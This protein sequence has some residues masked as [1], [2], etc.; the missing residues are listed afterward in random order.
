[1][2][3]KVKT[4]SREKI[5]NLF[6]FHR[7]STFH[8][9]C[10]LGPIAFNGIISA[11]SMPLW[12]TGFPEA[13]THESPWG[14]ASV[15]FVSS[16]LGPESASGC[17]AAPLHSVWKA[18]VWGRGDERGSDNWVPQISSVHKK[19]LCLDPWRHRPT[20]PQADDLRPPWSWEL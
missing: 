20:F 17:A 9:S 13:G 15:W 10:D 8:Q 11:K 12:W 14:H 7:K 2:K 19:S 1:M 4:Q 16:W 18:D 3:E 5:G 6:T